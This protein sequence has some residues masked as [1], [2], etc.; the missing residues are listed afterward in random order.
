LFA[1]RADNMLSSP[2]FFERKNQTT[3]HLIC[4][5]SSYGGQKIEVYIFLPKNLFFNSF[6]TR[7]TYKNIVRIVTNHLWSQKTQ[8]PKSTQAH[9]YFFMNLKVKHFYY[10]LLSSN[11]IIWYKY[12]LFGW[13]K[14][15]STI[16]FSFYHRDPL[17]SLSLFS[18][19]D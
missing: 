14:S 12:C 4:L 15:M 3:P 17:T 11:W 1:I 7:N 2:N 5:N 9:I 18:T 16:L 10:E 13:S 19:R 6:F 8:K